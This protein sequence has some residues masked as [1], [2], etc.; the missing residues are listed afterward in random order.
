MFKQ[1]LS[2][3]VAENTKFLKNSITVRLVKIVIY[4]VV[5]L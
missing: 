5:L 4:T 2:T 1:R 3:F